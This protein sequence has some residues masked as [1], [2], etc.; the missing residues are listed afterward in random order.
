[1]LC[2]LTLLLAVALTCRADDDLNTMLMESTFKIGGPS[3][4]QAGAVGIGTGFVLGKLMSP[5]SERA[6]YVL[7]TAGHV[8]DDIQGDYL[9]IKFRAKQAD[10][11]YRVVSAAMPLRS[12]G[13]ELYKKHESADV[14]AL[15][16]RPPA[17]TEGFPLLAADAF[18]IKESEIVK[19]GI[20]PGDDL[21]ALGYPLGAAA[22]QWEFP[23]LRSG[24]IASYPLAPISLIKT[25]LFDFHVYDGNSGGPVYFVL[26]NS[27]FAPAKA[28]PL[29][30]FV[31]RIVGLVS[32]QVRSTLVGQARLELAVIVPADLIRETMD[33]LPPA[34]PDALNKA[35]DP[36]L[37]QKATILP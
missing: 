5:G 9:T 13:K 10:G 20:H 16:I 32:Q 35:T 27:R 18:L 31:S 15:Y 17:G 23:I 14:V 36:D 7:V 6:W 29:G 37:I 3:K 19:Y 12:G 2:R 1:M 25:F 4:T 24:K 30:G 22:N 33:G 11:S 21:M 34:P 28:I 8:I 26:P